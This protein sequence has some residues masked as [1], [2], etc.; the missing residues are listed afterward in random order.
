[1]NTIELGISIR[2][3]LHCYHR[4]MLLNLVAIM[5]SGMGLQGRAVVVTGGTGALGSALIDVLV[6]EGATCVVP[7]VIEAE[8]KNFRFREHAQVRTLFPVELTDERQVA[9]LYDGVNALWAS[10]HIAGGFG[11]SNFVETTVE[12]FTAQLDMNLRTC[13]LTCRAAARRM[14]ANGLSGGRIVNISARPGLRPELGGGMVPYAVA[15]SGVATLTQSLAAELMAMGILVNA[16]A[17]SVLDTPA[18]RS[19]MPDAQHGDWVPLSAAADLIAYLASP[20]NAAVTGA[21]VP[22]YARS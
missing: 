15:K 6:R 20:A 1:M 4:P 17:P 13:F 19:A 11:M 12:Q 21:I 14:G 9:A 2:R 10:I 5:L 18:N 3:A 22:I 7:C 8:L 16:I